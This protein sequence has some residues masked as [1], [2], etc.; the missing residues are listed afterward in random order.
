MLSLILV[1][2]A[3]TQPSTGSGVRL[4]ADRPVARFLP[5]DVELP[6]TGLLGARVAGLPWRWAWALASVRSQE[7]CSR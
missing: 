6:S 4:E 1:V 2:L 5:A 7:A 3:Q